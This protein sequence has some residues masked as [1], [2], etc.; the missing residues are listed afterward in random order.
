MCCFLF[1]VYFIIIICQRTVDCV[2]VVPNKSSIGRQFRKDSTLVMD[3]LMKFSP[4][5]ASDLEESLKAN[6]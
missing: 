4:Q 6:G 2:E 3:A 1:I 5:E